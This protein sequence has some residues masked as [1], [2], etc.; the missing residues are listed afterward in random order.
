[1][2]KSWKIVHLVATF[3]STYVTNGV[4]LDI[5]RSISVNDSIITNKGMILKNFFDSHSYTISYL[6]A[7]AEQT[8][9]KQQ[10][11]YKAFSFIF[12]QKLSRFSDVFVV[13]C[14]LIVER[15]RLLDKYTYL[16]SW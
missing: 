10:T 5:I 7:I 15:L 6:R 11:S 14:G 4:W 1:M 2:C 13:Y 16:V 8:K 9:N 3:F 12:V